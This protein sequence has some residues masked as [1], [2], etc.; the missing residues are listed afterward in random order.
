[1][2]FSREFC[3]NT[4]DLDLNNVVS[5]SGQL[6][7]MLDA[8]NFQ[9]EEC[10][11][12]Y[13][14]LFDSGY[15]FVLSRTAVDFYVPLH[16]HD[17]V[18][19]ETWAVDG[20]GTIFNRCYRILK[21]NTVIAQGV[22][23]WA[24]VNMNDRHLMRHGD[25]KLNYHT[26]EIL[27]VNAPIRFRIP[28]SSELASVGRYTVRY[29][30]VD[31]NRHMNN[32][33]YADILAAFLPSME[34]RRISELAINYLSEAPLGETLEVFHTQNNDEHYFRTLR[35]DGTVN[36]EC[37]MKLTSLEGDSRPE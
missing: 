10:T 16:S 22:S 25:V 37:F 32:T 34:D 27:A 17:N 6:R 4:H 9:M 33:K 28:A 14:E 7:Y 29:P 26:D 15:S 21:D 30:D 23:A 18:M 5:A 20:H 1:M 13:D 12:S 3:I 19:C 8:V 2:K 24:L 31:R 35:Q 36:V 11:P